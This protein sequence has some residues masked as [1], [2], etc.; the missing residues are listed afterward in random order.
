MPIREFTIVRA[1]VPAGTEITFDR[2]FA[3]WEVTCSFCADVMARDEPA[4]PVDEQTDDEVQAEQLDPGT[5]SARVRTDRFAV[6]AEIVAAFAE[7]GAIRAQ[8]ELEC[9]QACAPGVLS[10]FLPFLSEQLA[11]LIRRDVDEPAADVD[12]PAATGE[13][14]ISG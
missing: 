10:P 2:A 5:L 1:D 12:E 3:G 6:K 11:A 8:L 14:A 9:C 13:P 4:A 7:A